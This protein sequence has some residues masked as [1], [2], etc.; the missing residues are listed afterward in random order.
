MNL[1]D[2]HPHAAEGLPGFADYERKSREAFGPLLP[3]DAEGSMLAWLLSQ[4]WGSVLSRL[5]AEVYEPAGLGR[6]SFRILVMAYLEPDGVEPSTIAERSSTTPASV[7][8]VLN[9]LQKRGFVDRTIDPNDRRRVRVLLTDA[10][11]AAVEE[12]T[13]AQGEILVDMFSGLTESERSALGSALR[14]FLVSSWQP[15]EAGLSGSPDEEDDEE[16]GVSP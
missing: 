12:G 2:E 5:E 11:R 8:G 10:G 1:E 6:G 13:R 15:G 7:S 4:A 3:A 9:T 16:A 14:T